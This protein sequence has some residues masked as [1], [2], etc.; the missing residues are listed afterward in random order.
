MKNQIKTGRRG[1]FYKAVLSCVLVVAGVLLSA[2]AKAPTNH[3]SLEGRVFTD[4][5]VRASGKATMHVNELS[6]DKADLK[7]K[8][9]LEF[10]NLPRSAFEIKGPIFRSN[11]STWSDAVYV[12]QPEALYANAGV[13]NSLTLQGLAIYDTDA[14][15]NRFYLRSGDEPFVQLT[16]SVREEKTGG[17]LAVFEFP[18]SSLPEE[19]TNLLDFDFAS[20]LSD[21]PAPPAEYEIITC[22][23]FDLPDEIEVAPHSD[24][25]GFGISHPLY[26]PT[27]RQFEQALRLPRQNVVA[28]KRQPLDASLE[29]MITDTPYIALNYKDRHD[30]SVAKWSILPVG[31]DP[32]IAFSYRRVWYSS[33]SGIA[34]FYVDGGDVVPL[35]GGRLSPQID[36][37]A[38]YEQ[39]QKIENL[40]VP[41]P[42][43]ETRRAG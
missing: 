38:L 42:P 4:D 22:S 14:F 36:E 7:L 39:F 32:N 8:G 41:P 33:Q 12:V 31:Q 24:K 5:P 17:Y 25:A 43:V 19:Q 18:I 1:S 30:F 20:H 26:L 11:W 23:M 40:P 15:D 2:C 37:Q 34:A 35:L 6:I 16:I 9:T 29:R 3:T 10:P 21:L 13:R 28:L 27:L